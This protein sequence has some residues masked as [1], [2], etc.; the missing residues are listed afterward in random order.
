MLPL[1]S[2]NHLIA[3]APIGYVF[4]YGWDVAKPSPGIFH[5]RRRA[6]VG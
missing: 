5:M 1:W 2:D 4:S 3:S 6:V